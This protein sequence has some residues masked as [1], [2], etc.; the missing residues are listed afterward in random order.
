[1]SKFRQLL[2]HHLLTH[3]V[4]ALP[5]GG[6][7]TSGIGKYHGKASFDAFVNKRAVLKKNFNPLIEAAAG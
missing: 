5:F 7:G 6:V 4:D 2:W 3:S 1:M